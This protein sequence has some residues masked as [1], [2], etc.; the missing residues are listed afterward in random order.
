MAG[1]KAVKSDKLLFS[2]S[3]NNQPSF[4]KAMAGMHGKRKKDRIYP[5]ASV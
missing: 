5:S 1:N 2:R 3:L 4:A